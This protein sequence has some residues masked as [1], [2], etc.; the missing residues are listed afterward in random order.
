MDLTQ[1]KFEFLVILLILVLTI[2][3]VCF[4]YIFFYNL[5][6]FSC[7]SILF[8]GIIFSLLFNQ[9]I[10]EITLIITALAVTA[11]IFKLAQKAI[12]KLKANF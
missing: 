10:N 8:S 5:I 12:R 2:A 6:G 1:L 9:E 7:S 4:R 11:F 3:L